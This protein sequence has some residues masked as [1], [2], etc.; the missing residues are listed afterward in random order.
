M[1]YTTISI[2][3]LLLF[4]KCQP[5]L[6][7]TVSEIHF[8]H[9]STNIDEINLNN[10]IGIANLCNKDTDIHLKVFGFSDT[11][12]TEEHNMELSKTRSLKVYNY[13]ME[14]SKLQ[15]NNTTLKWFGES[16]EI[17]ELEKKGQ[18]NCVYISVQIP[19]GINLSMDA[20]R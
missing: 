13:I 11:I 4:I 17:N 7:G 19:K 8:D 3:A 15:I 10:L 5:K 1:K 18:Q 6:L 20:S 12:G 14:H 9:D 16:K 2:I